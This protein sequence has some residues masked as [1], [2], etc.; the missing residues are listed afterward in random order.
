LEVRVPVEDLDLSDLELRR[1]I[2]IVR[3][4]PGLYTGMTSGESGV[5]TITPSHNIWYFEGVESLQDYFAALERARDDERAASEIR[6]DG[7]TPPPPSPSFSSGAVPFRAAMPAFVDEVRLQDLRSLTQTTF[8]LRRLVAMC[9][10]L[11]VCAEN[12][13]FHATIMLTR[14]IIDH[15]PPI[16]N[17]NSFDEVVNNVPAAKSTKQSLQHLSKS[18]RSIADGHLHIRIRSIE[19]LP[20]R[21]QV[22]FSRDLDVLLAEIVRVLS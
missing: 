21:T 15:V 16:F 14:A 3:S 12:E 1:L 2:E 5:I 18:A 4:A 7:F 9:E 10:E 17:T 22:N 11:N 13:C 6:R 20:S 19:T 8:D